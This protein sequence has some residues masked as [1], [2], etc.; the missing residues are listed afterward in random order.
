MMISLRNRLL[1]GMVAGLTLLLVCSG[2]LVYWSAKRSIYAQCDSNI[3]ATA[4]MLSAAVEDQDGKLKVEFDAAAAPRFQKGERPD[5]YL[6]VLPGRAG[7]TGSPSLNEAMASYFMTKLGNDGFRSAYLPNGQAVRTL[8]LTVAPRLDPEDADAQKAAAKPFTLIVARDI[9]ELKS[10]L[11]LLQ[12]LLFASG[13]IT[14][15]LS[16]IVA[17]TVV[18]RGLRP[19][20]ALTENIDHVS[21]Q[22]LGTRLTR[23]GV[24]PEL[25]PVVDQLNSMLARLEESFA[26]QKRFNADVAHEL[27]TPLSGLSTTLEVALLRTR[28]EKEY[29]DT[30]STCLPIV[31]SMQLMV[32][33]LLELTRP[34]T[35]RTV[36]PTVV[37]LCEIFDSSWNGMADKAATHVLTFENGLPQ[38]LQLETDR[39]RLAMIVTNVLDNAVEYTN[40]GGRIWVQG[41]RSDGRVIFSLSNTGSTLSEEDASRVFDCF[42]RGDQARSN[43]GVH[44]GLGLAIVKK[45][46][47]SLNG[48]VE[49]RT[50][51]QGVFE[52]EFGFPAGS[53]RLKQDE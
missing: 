16:V 7:Y 48:S 32:S 52:V 44:C 11:D 35:S 51:Q 20:R 15:V 45:L 34:D 43:T 42:W 10:H 33:N 40:P 23:G 47:E 41:R 21:D 36:R 18:D 25:L 39:A 14:V 6:F 27:R 13:A 53:S 8:R 30:I 3:A 2:M 28:D 29:R 49:I 38:D 12:W 50:S 31:R 37:R 22:S 5:Y 1:I 4:Q 26:R 19:M 9:S 17:V 46:T 24:P